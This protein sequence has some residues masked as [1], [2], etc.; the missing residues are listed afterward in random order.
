MKIG[1]EEGFGTF[2]AKLMLKIHLRGRESRGEVREG[3]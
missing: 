3:G 1:R 2:H